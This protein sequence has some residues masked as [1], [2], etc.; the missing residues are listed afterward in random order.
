MSKL[1]HYYKFKYIY[2]YIYNINT[3]IKCLKYQLEFNNTLVYLPKK[4]KPPKL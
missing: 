1:T 4:K 2:I 3:Y